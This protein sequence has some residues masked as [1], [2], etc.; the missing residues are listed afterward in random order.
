MVIDVQPLEKEIAQYDLRVIDLATGAMV[1]QP[2]LTVKAGTTVDST[3]ENS[4]VHYLVHIE[5][6]E[7]G[8]LAHLSV[9]E[10]GM[11]MDMLSMFWSNTTRRARLRVPGAVRG[12]D[13]VNPP[14]VMKHV[15]PIYTEA[16][17]K[18]R[19]EGYVLLDIRVDKTGDVRDV[20]VLQ[21]LTWGLS[22][23]AVDA[24]KQWKFQPATMRDGT[25]VESLVSY[26]VVFRLPSES[27]PAQ[28]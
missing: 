17:R 26:G 8:V 13:A 1:S 6:K 9:E 14:K 23:A 19:V 28:P 4:G 16:A 22:Q 3:S 24:V 10:N 5:S 25:P 21:E 2:R 12:E 20:V 7:S 18:N 15:D 11:V 27:V